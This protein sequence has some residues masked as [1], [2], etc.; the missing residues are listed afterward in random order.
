MNIPP[1]VN[2]DTALK[3]YYSNVELGNREIKELF[4][5]R[6]TTTIVRLKKAVKVEMDKRKIYSYGANRV[7]TKVAYEVFGID[8]D[9]LERRRAKLKKLDL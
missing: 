4:G 9:D 6:S 7:N 3:I 2:I 8:V 1:I 5:Q